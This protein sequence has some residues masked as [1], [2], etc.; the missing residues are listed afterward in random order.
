MNFVASTR[1]RTYYWV[2]CNGWKSLAP[3]NLRYFRTAA[4]ARAVGLRVSTQAGCAGPSAVQGTADPTATPA[5]PTEAPARSAP[6]ATTASATATC[7]VARVIDGDTLDCADGPRVRLLLIDAPEMNQG[8]F[9]AVAKLQLEALAPVG[10]LLSLESDIQ[11]Q[12]RYGRTLA[13]LYFDDGRMM[14]EELLRAGVAVVSVYPPNV[15]HVDRL[16]AAVD[17]A[18]ASKRGLWA[19]SAFECSPADHRAGRCDR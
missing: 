18:R 16:R 15:K 1:G 7:T 17:S 10:T 3:A 9:G 6:G 11:K 5:T 14:N 2:G 13:Y 4:D 8:P 19:T 12:D